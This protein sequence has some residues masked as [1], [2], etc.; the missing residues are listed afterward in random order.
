MK[1]LPPKLS[2][3]NGQRSMLSDKG[4][5]GMLDFIGLD[6]LCWTTARF[7]LV[8]AAGIPAGAEMN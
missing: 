6:G 5:C 8:E 4:L 3:V 7:K 1:L 2:D